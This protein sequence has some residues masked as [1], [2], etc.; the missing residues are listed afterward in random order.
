MALSNNTF[1]WNGIVTT[2]IE[3]TLA[4]FPEVLGW[5]EQRVEMDGETIMFAAGGEPLAHVRGPQMEGEP[6]WWNNYLRVE[7][8]DAA[9]EATRAAG[10]EVLVPPTDIIPGRF[11]TVKTPS[12]AVFTLFKEAKA[13]DSDA[14]LGVGKLHW[15]DLHSKDLDADLAYLRDHLKF[16][17]Q[18]MDMPTGPYTIL[19]PEGNARA[20]V[21]AGQN[22]Q[23]PS[24][25]VAWIHVESVDDTLGR[26]RNAGGKVVAEPW[27][28]PGVGRLALLSDP[29]G[30]TFGVIT[31]PAN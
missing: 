13:D 4:F 1:C 20:G 22:P 2:D 12:G 15:V 31:P 8:V 28:V 10:G 23:A 14:G 30:V 26:A 3:R 17:T 18:T 9:A 16:E 24:M 25:W 19:D 29:A 27:D 21:M 7:D 11:A 5:T 6:S